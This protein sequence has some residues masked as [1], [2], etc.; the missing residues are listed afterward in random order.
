MDA[1]A[2]EVRRQSRCGVKMEASLGKDEPC[3]ERRDMEERRGVEEGL[4]EEK[5]EVE[6]RVER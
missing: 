5:S 3:E 4:Q 1:A 2:K 6:K